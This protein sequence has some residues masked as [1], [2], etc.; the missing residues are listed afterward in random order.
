MNHN[1]VKLESMTK[2]FEFE[3]LSRDINT[4]DNIDDLK[5]LSKYFL[6]LY[7]KQQEVISTL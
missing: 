4:L 5:N 7:L 1:D 3:K 2:L 6:K